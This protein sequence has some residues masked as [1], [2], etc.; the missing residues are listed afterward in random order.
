MATGHRIRAWRNTALS[1]TREQRVDLLGELANG[2]LLH[3]ELQSTNQPSMAF[4]MS[5][6]A[7]AIYAKHGRFP[8]QLVLYAGR[9]WRQG[10]CGTGGAWITARVGYCY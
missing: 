1:R 2:E 7:H 5:D 8:H 3:I 9:S 10:A 6:Y 4:R